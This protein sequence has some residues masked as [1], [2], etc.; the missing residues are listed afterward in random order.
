MQMNEELAYRLVAED[1]TDEEEAEWLEVLY[2][3]DN[4]HVKHDVTEY[5]SIY[6]HKPTGKLYQIF[7]SQSYEYGMDEYVT[8]QE[9]EEVEKTI[10]TYE[11]VN[12][13]DK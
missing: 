12:K 13:G 6:K 5:Y 10:K 11:P 4:G 8:F 3:V 2:D 9:V 1:I 7:Y